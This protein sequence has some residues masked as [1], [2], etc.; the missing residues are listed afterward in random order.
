MY[1]PNVTD[2]DRENMGLPIHDTTRTPSAKP[3]GVHGIEL[4]WA[5][6]DAPPA[7]EKDLKN[8]AFDTKTPYIFTFDESDRGNSPA[9]R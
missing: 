9:N 1:N 3:K 6:L 2:V 5:L 8:S 4:C 7:S